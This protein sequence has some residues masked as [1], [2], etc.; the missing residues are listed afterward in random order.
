DPTFAFVKSPPW[1]EFAE[2]VTKEAFSELAEALGDQCDEVDL[3]SVFDAGLTMQK[4]I[5]TA[6]VA[7]F[8]GPILAKAPDAISKGLAERIVEGKDISAVD[9]NTALDVRET[10]YAGLEEVF[11][12]YDAIITPASPGPAPKGLETTGNPIFNAMW[13]F[14][15]VSCVTLP[16]LEADGMPFGV[17]LVGPRF[18]DARLLRT[19]NWLTRHLTADDDN[20]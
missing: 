11:E 16:L 10:L 3:P 4:V 9:Y 14:L 15:G 8:Y 7:K 12:R 18:D 20:D 19:A 13:T 17:Q 2:D 5:Q 1:D 6:D